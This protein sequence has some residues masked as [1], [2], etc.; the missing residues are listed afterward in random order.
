[1]K[2]HA[3]FGIAAV[4]AVCLAG[5]TMLS[6]ARA[7]EFSDRIDRAKSTLTQ[8]DKLIDGIQARQASTGETAVAM[9]SMKCPACGMEM[10]ST[11]KAGFRAVKFGGKTFYCCK[12]CDMS[13]FAD[14]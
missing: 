7:D 5:L 11:P 1:M 4:A 2:I 3:R 12:G 9:K 6:S 10:P 14:K 8:I 13:K